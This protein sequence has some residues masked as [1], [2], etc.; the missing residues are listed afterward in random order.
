MDD[1]KLGLN[2]LTDIKVCYKEYY[3]REIESRKIIEGKII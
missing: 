2:E 3:D 1:L